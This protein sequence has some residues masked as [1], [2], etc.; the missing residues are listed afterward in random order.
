MLVGK[1]GDDTSAWRA[2]YE[3]LH[4]E[5]R[6]IHL[7]HGACILADGGG[8]GRHA[9]RTAA[10]LVDDGKQD[11]VVDLVET[12]LVDV[13]RTERYVGYLGVYASAALDLGEV[14][15]ATQQSVGDTRRA[16]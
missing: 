15:H 2:L 6:L 10:K 11:L 3:A 14:A 5:V 8:D 12:I 13:E 7:L 1:R 4:D 16:A 9:N